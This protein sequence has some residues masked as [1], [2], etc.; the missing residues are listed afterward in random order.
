MMEWSSL[1]PELRVKIF[2]YLQGGSLH[3]CRQVCKT[4]NNFILENIWGS[5]D[6]REV[7]EM[8]L[9]DNMFGEESNY[10]EASETIEVGDL[11]VVGDKSNC[12]IEA[13]FENFVVLSSD[14]TYRRKNYINVKVYNVV[15]K[16]IWRVGNFG[17]LFPEDNCL[18][19]AVDLSKSLLSIV[20]GSDACSTINVFS[21]DTKEIIFEEVFSEDFGFINDK[22][23]SLLAL[24]FDSKVEVLS[25]NDHNFSRY[26]CTT[27]VPIQFY[28]REYEDGVCHTYS[29][30]EFPNL[31]HF[32]TIE[33]EG[34]TVFVWIIDDF[35]KTVKI[36][37]YVAD[38]ESFLRQ[39]DR[40]VV[41]D[42]LYVS[43]S[44]VVISK[45]QQTCSRLCLE[46][47]NDEGDLIK[48]IQ[49]HSWFTSQ[50][51]WSFF[52]L[53]I[54]ENKLIVCNCEMVMIRNSGGKVLID[55]GELLVPGENNN[56]SMKTFSEL[57]LKQSLCSMN[58]SSVFSVAIEKAEQMEPKMKVIK[59]NFWALD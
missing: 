53:S 8:K 2:L 49:L 25:F 27:D 21:V 22:S 43:S 20:Y 23:S 56:V 45:D 19:L 33:D 41:F 40:L 52:C 18:T 47:F 10:V 15:T 13:A 54:F 7:L 59:L 4:W 36:H 37:K 26:S 16:D 9:K 55:L 14:D 31:C 42:V 11:G 12:K 34:K 24:L 6:A 58:H 5:Q 50:D 57:K 29:H 46:V 30:L 32:Q 35:E 28:W 1:P 3:K 44:F 17:P 38:L 48:K 51:S 39:S